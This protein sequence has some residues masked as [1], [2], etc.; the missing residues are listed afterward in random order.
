MEVGNDF[1][2]KKQKAQNIKK[3]IGQSDSLKWIVLI[4]MSRK[5][6][7]SQAEKLE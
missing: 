1:L 4:L 7:K 6:V 3:K 2:S 5:E